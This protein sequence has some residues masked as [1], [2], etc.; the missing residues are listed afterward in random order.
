MAEFVAD[1]LRTSGAQAVDFVYDVGLKP[2][3]NKREGSDKKYEYMIRNP[4][5]N[6]GEN[7][8]L[9]TISSLPLPPNTKA[10]P[11]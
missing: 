5:D 3:N 6:D 11:K 2:A 7:A 8:L 10:L 4:M 1:K 9:R